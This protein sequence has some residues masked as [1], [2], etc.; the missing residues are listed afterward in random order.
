MDQPIH[1][2]SPVTV[3]TPLGTLAVHLVG[4]QPPTLLLWSGLFFDS[5]QHLPLARHLASRGIGTALVDPP[6]FGGSTLAEGAELRMDE[7]GSAFL[8]VAGTVVPAGM[9][10]FLGGTSWGGC[11]AIAAACSCAAAPAA[12]KP[13][14]KGI[15]PVNTP[16]A[17]GSN[18]GG[19][20]FIPLTARLPTWAFVAGASG[21]LIGRTSLAGSRAGEIKATLSGSMAAVRGSDAQRAAEAVLQR[22]E[23]LSHAIG[24]VEVPA[25]VVLGTEDAMYSVDNLRA[26]WGAAARMRAEMGKP[27]MGAVV[28][29][30]GTGHSSALEAPEQVGEEIARFVKKVL[31]SK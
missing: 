16:I 27:G 8:K 10:Y 21:S 1:A 29:I 31:G 14:M 9:P 15:V 28:E 22:R 13:V 6:G 19:A 3:E 24:R 26:R 18:T 17:G 7:C 5:S 4:P 11:A 25:L 12:G 30:E 23:D 20:R 2:A